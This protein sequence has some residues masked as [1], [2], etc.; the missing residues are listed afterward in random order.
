MD[1]DRFLDNIL[2]FVELLRRAGLPVSSEQTMD[3]S[4]ALTLIDIGEREQVYY[5]ARTLLISRYEHLRLFDVLFNRFAGLGLKSR[6]RG[7]I[8]R[9]R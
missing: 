8:D 2:L 9:F 1:T 4:R 3:F 7:G 6:L 5:A